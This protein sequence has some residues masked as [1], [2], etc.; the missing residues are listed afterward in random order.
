LENVSAK[1]YLRIQPEQLGFMYKRFPVTAVNAQQS[2]APSAPAVVEPLITT[3]PV[4]QAA[5]QP[6][7]ATGAGGQGGSQISLQ[8]WVASPMVASNQMQEIGVQVTENGL[9]MINTDTEISLQLPDGQ[10]RKYYMDPT[11]ADGQT[12]VQLQ[13]IAASNSTLI[14]FEVCVLLVGGQKLCSSGQYSIWDPPA[15][16]P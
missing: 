3:Q 14:P 8:V 15:P 9:P 11:G 6:V 10:S 13:P 16:T 2:V 7:S 1:D 4:E 5:S 12:R